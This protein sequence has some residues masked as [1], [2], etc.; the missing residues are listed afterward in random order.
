MSCMDTLN[1]LHEYDEEGNFKEAATLAEHLLE[2]GYEG[3]TFVYTVLS[4][5]YYT[6]GDTAKTIE[7]LEAALKGDYVCDFVKPN[8]KG[9]VL[10]KAILHMQLSILYDEH[11]DSNKSKEELTIAR[12][13]GREAFGEKYKDEILKKL[14][15]ANLI[16][17]KNNS[18]N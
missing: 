4:R 8:G 14:A 2:N 10:N 16:Y 13:V 12:E 1:P 3:D 17:M 9:L 11:E 7:M 18:N 5:A 15:Y 6:Q